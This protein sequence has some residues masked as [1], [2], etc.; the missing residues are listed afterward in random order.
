M[1][2]SEESVRLLEE[3]AHLGDKMVMYKEDGFNFL[4]DYV[5]KDM[6]SEVFA[7]FAKI[8]PS[9]TGQVTE[10]QKILFA[11]ARIRKKIDDVIAMGI[12]ARE[13]LRALNEPEV[14]IE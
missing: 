9:D 13:E 6:E 8:D 2:Y 12:V 7:S 1:A 11:I 10:L 5:L 3:K 14:D 4:D